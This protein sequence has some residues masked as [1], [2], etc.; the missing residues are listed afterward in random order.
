MPNQA[1]PYTPKASGELPQI[2]QAI[3]AGN[4]ASATADPNAVYSQPTQT[5]IQPA[6]DPT[7]PQQFA[8]P[9]QGGG[10]KVGVK[11]ANYDGEH[12]R[13]DRGQRMVAQDFVPHPDPYNI[14]AYGQSFSQPAFNLPAPAI[15]ARLQ[16]LAQEDAELNKLTG[17]LFA[18]D[19]REVVPPQYSRS[20][21]ALWDRGENEYR[22]SIAAQ[23]GGR[24][25]A[26]AR[27]IAGKDPNNPEAHRGYLRFNRDMNEIGRIITHDVGQAEKNIEGMLNRSVKFDQESFDASQ[28]LVN[29]AAS[30][31]SEGLGDINAL[32][33]AGSD[34]KKAT[35]L[36]F[37]LQNKE[38]GGASIDDH[39][40]AFMANSFGKN[41]DGT[42]KFQTGRD[43][44]FRFLYHEDQ[45]TA[46]KMID[47]LAEE[48]Y[49][50]FRSEYPTKEAFKERLHQWYPTE[51][52]IKVDNTYTPSA[53][54]GGSQKDLTKQIRLVPRVE[55]VQANSMGQGGFD[56]PTL[57]FTD[58]T[59]NALMKQQY[60]SNGKKMYPMYIQYNPRTD[61]TLLWG[62]DAEVVDK[63]MAGKTEEEKIQAWTQMIVD[64]QKLK[65]NADAKN[66]LTVGTNDSK[67]SS[68]R[69]TK[70]R[71][72]FS[73]PLDKN[74]DVVTT[75]TQGEEWR[76]WLD[77]AR[78]SGSNKAPTKQV[79]DKQVKTIKA[80]YPDAVLD[81]KHGW[82]AKGPD[83]KWHKVNQ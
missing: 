79:D 32:M 3:A 58:G 78:G 26:A 41:S 46:D 12:R 62:E 63:M 16:G 60:V 57:G 48:I 21:N 31:G 9:A 13:G 1:G 72:L 52:T 27:A 56:L 77:G 51:V 22:A 42:P 19:T 10:F 18:K 82:I 80:S 38:K 81:P 47:G 50:Q 14:T 75:I 54:G 36:P 61:K 68:M 17:E 44:I 69:D 74:E 24:Q 71:P 53:G 70:Q 11:P 64:A 66:S 55:T 65:D 73:V 25:D 43:G 29:A 67:S 59:G 49:P 7:Q 37:F 83:G 76:Q 5:T 4:A 40:K 15:A 20:Y 39:V 28:E 8:G 45:E 33:K 2:D 6:V 23:Y 35:T 34:Y 30:R